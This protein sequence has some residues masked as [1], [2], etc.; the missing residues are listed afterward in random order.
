MTKKGGHGIFLTGF[1]PALK[2]FKPFRAWL[3][4]F[5]AMT[6]KGGGMVFFPLDF[7]QR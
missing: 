2:T 1:H 3:D 7:I 5:L 6:K 4:T